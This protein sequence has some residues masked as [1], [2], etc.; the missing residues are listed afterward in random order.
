MQT[1]RSPSST[2]RFTRDLRFE[3]SALALIPAQTKHNNA[4]EAA[5]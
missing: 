5:Q 2:R 1:S 3:A 4:P